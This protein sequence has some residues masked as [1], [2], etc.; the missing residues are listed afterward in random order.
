MGIAGCRPKLSIEADPFHHAVSA[1]WM[2]RLSARGSVLGRRRDSDARVM[3]PGTAVA[4]NCN[5]A[6]DVAVDTSGRR[7]ILSVE[8]DP[9]HR[10][11]S[12]GRRNGHGGARDLAAPCREVGT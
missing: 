4:R 9:F 11:I 8:A 10:A 7:S 6:D 3:A 5:R 1:G 12:A 2:A